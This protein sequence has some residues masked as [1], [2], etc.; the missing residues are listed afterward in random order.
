[1]PLFGGVNFN[2]PVWG[3]YERHF[4]TRPQTAHRAVHTYGISDSVATQAPIL[5]E[6]YGTQI[7]I[8][9]SR[10]DGDGSSSWQTQTP[11]RPL[12]YEL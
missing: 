8:F 5:F 4:D 2:V 7:K 11:R 6:K 3:R 9:I 1:M 10:Y 12:D